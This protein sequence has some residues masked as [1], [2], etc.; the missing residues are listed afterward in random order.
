MLCRG[1]NEELLQQHGNQRYCNPECRLLLTNG[2]LRG[3]GHTPNH[4]RIR[5]E[6]YLARRASGICVHCGKKSRPN[7]CE[8]Q[9][10]A[11][12]VRTRRLGRSETERDRINR[13]RSE[14]RKRN[15]KLGT[16]CGCGNTLK[17]NDD[18]K[19][20]T[21][22]KKH[23][24]HVAGNCCKC[25]RSRLPGKRYCKA[26]KRGNDRKSLRRNH[27]D[28]ADIDALEV[29]LC[30]KRMVTEADVDAESW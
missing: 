3:R 19:C 23:A 5:A 8:C 27:G 15:R 20:G 24:R 10:C 26:C 16:I 14:R 12:K 18:K 29:L 22:I 25:S 11:D 21:C 1:C 30:L 6:V 28:D 13:Q 2:H 17:A 4:A 7:R 9:R